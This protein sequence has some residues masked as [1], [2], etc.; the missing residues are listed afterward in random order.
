MPS[1]REK[2]RLLYFGKSATTHR[3]R[4]GLLIFDTVTILFIIGTFFV[5]VG[6]NGSILSSVS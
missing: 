1:L 6:S 2:T 3:F 5:S 4:Y